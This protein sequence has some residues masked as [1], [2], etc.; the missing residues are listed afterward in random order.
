MKYSKAFIILFVMVCSAVVVARSDKHGKK[1]GPAV[2]RTVAADPNVLISVCVA[3]GEIKVRGWD[4]NEVRA[5][6]SDSPELELRRSGPSA[7]GSAKEIIV[8]A[9]KDQRHQRDSCSADADI[10]IDVP[11]GASVKVQIRDGDIH[12]T[13]V[14]AIQAK[15]M[16]GDINI[17][18]VKGK[19]EADTLSGNISLTNSNGSAKL[20]S[21]G[22]NVE[23]SGVG[24]AAAGDALNAASVGGDVTIE[25]S[26]Y[27]TVTA[28]SVGGNLNLSGPLSRDARY[29]LN[30]ISGDIHLTLPADASFRLDAKLSQN[31]DFTSDFPL[32]VKKEDESTESVPKPP[33]PPKTKHRVSV[34]P[35]PPKSFYGLQHISAVYGTGDALLTISS[36][37][38]GVYLQRK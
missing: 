11:R 8:L 22:G 29:E 18:G 12:V 33:T 3:S 34:P 7:S 30:T 38:G 32:K 37:S 17:A 5:R 9:S 31:A 10:E 28:G 23:A 26:G 16:N 6:T 14:L 1:S 36:F 4:R 13:D 25:K 27:A 20:H 35:D 24:P 19:A 21:V 2:E 15:T